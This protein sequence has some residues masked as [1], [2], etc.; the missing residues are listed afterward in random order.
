M[1]VL[2]L[3]IWVR[4][5]PA[6][7]VEDRERIERTH[8]SRCLG[9]VPLHAKHQVGAVAEATQIPESI[10]PRSPL[11]S[12]PT[13]L[14][15]VL[16]RFRLF[17]SPLLS[18]RWL[19][20]RQRQASSEPVHRTR[21]PPRISDD[22]YAQPLPV[23]RHD[24]SRFHRASLFILSTSCLSRLSL[25]DFCLSFLVHLSLPTLS[26]VSTLASIPADRLKQHSL[27]A[28]TPSDPARFANQD[29][30]TCHARTTSPYR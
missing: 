16:L 18:L 24:R 3:L 25:A 27:H 29:E 4:R 30:A 11:S 22:P 20:Q 14:S 28:H 8:W 26:S 12:S 21:F 15:C 9:A 19:R 17:R 2:D 6:Q 5:I 23:T 7:R 10:K 1:A 13:L